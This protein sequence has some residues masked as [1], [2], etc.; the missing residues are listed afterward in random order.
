MCHLK[1]IHEIATTPCLA[2]ATA[3]PERKEQERRQA[4]TAWSQETRTVRRGVSTC[5]RN[6]P[7]AVKTLLGSRGGKEEE[8]KASRGISL[9]RSAK[10]LHQQSEK[11]ALKPQHHFTPT[12]LAEIKSGSV[13]RNAS[14]G[15]SWHSTLGSTG[16]NAEHVLTMGLPPTG[17]ACTGQGQR[18]ECK[19]QH[20]YNWPKPGNKGRNTWAVSQGRQAVATAISMDATQRLR[21]QT[22]PRTDSMTS[23]L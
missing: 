5:S 4:N 12:R 14:G 7:S 16:S 9:T 6:K 19:Q 21:E 15:Q 10:G 17:G 13:G 11:S 2:R 20:G 22:K 23:S 8:K 1:K 3:T 18:P